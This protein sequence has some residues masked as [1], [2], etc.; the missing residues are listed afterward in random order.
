MFV[1]D[2]VTR[3][4][5]AANAAALKFYGYAESV[6]L[7]KSFDDL[8]SANTVPSDNPAIQHRDSLGKTLYVNVQI[9][10]I[11]FG[12]KSMHLVTVQDISGTGE[13]DDPASRQ[14]INLLRAELSETRRR[15]ETLEAALRK[16]EGAAGAQGQHAQAGGESF[17]E[18]A[19]D[20]FFTKAEQVMARQAAQAAVTDAEG[21]VREAGEIANLGGWGME[22]ASRTVRWSEMTAAI[23]GDPARRTVSVEDSLQFHAP[24]YRE[25]LT[26]A[27]EAGLTQGTSFDE[28]TEIVTPQGAR[29]WVRTT[30]KAIRDAGTDAIVGL[31]GA[32]QDISELVESQT[33]SSVLSLRLEET[34]EGI[35][36]GF[37]T[38]DRDWTLTFVNKSAAGLVR[39]SQKEITGRCIW[40]V[41]P[42]V[43]GTQFEVEY[44]K[45]MSLGE[46]R[47]FRAFYEDCGKWFEVAAHP[48]S[49]GLG[50]AFRDVSAEQVRDEKLKILEIAIGRLNDLVIITD[51]KPLD[52]P[53]GPKIIYVNDA[54]E[55][56]TGY[57]CDEVIGRTP[58]CL[59]GTGTQRSALR[60]IAS[61]L[62]NRQ[63]VRSELINYTKSG[64]PFWM[65]LDIVP[66]TRDDGQVT[67]WVAVARDISARKTE[68]QRISVSEERFRLIA[69]ATHTVVWDCNLKTNTICWTENMVDIFGYDASN[70]NQDM[71]WWDQHIHPDEQGDVL[72]GISSVINGE[73]NNWE[74]R[75]R[76]LKADGRYAHVVD[77]ITVI[78]DE[79]GSAVRIL[80]NM[81]DISDRYDLEEKLRQSQKMEAVGQ[82][83]GGVAHDFNN[84][85]AIILGNLELLK[86]GL[87]GDVVDKRDAMEL[88]DAGITA[89]S[90]GAGLTRNMLAYARKARLKPVDTDLNGVV[91]E[92]E[93]WMRRT[94]KSN[95]TITTALQEDL[96]QIRVDQ[97][98]LQNALVNLLVN[99]RDAL[100]GGGRLT[101]ETANVYMEGEPIG[102][103]SETVLVGDH[104]MLSVSD[105]GIGMTP[106]VILRMFDPFFTTKQV[107]KGTGLGL[108]M[109]QGFVKQSFGGIRVCSELGKGTTITLY[110]RAL[111]ERKH[112]TERAAQGQIS[113]ASDQIRRSRILLVEDQEELL[114]LFRKILETAGYD[115]T[116][117][118]SADLAFAIFEKDP[119]F[120]LVLT[121]IVM[122]GQLQGPSLATACREIRPDAPFIF[123]S[124]YAGD[125]TVSGD[126]L[127]AED[128]RLMK[129]VS[130]AALLKAIRERF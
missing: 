126:G 43:V 8:V 120:D 109:V 73:K 49:E 103:P 125:A 71:T 121:D 98:S 38:L 35:S 124:G 23:L 81:T 15:L 19:G 1:F 37:M 12:D 78:R 99:A 108:S 117:A 42:K 20:S 7:S 39:R 96:W 48:T 97:G 107:G 2:P 101:I 28:I 130:S 62:R 66:I 94:I 70:I 29:K 17:E 18:N 22:M 25:R 52:K 46:T 82:L 26:A 105:D 68:E 4:I 16:S 129:P 11:R 75:Y 112:T 90:R 86:D 53:D 93:L 64:E 10:D 95:V 31:Q 106:A 104:V 111:T 119:T 59:Q 47:R 84:L 41:I 44:R 127:T 83:T 21:F 74:A 13:A 113:A 67:Y 72:S 92:T 54:F 85:L 9:S 63:P 34:L 36:D 60:R 115:V 114:A 51:A 91:R 50:V 30:G 27:I 89:V 58:R 79:D 5:Q 6:F 3:K 102:D 80:G 87:Q 116:P 65:D 56:L 57:A 110:F 76:F 40:D 61:S 128:M 123:M 69:A 77:Q 100:T 88:I 14:M 118:N 24:E 45:A 122:P 55:R 32:F 33:Q